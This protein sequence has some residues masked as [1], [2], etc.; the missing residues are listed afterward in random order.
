MR[1]PNQ[2]SIYIIEHT[3]NGKLFTS[4]DLEDGKINK[5]S[6]QKICSVDKEDEYSSFQD[7][8]YSILNAYGPTQSKHNPKRIYISV[9]PGYN[10]DGMTQDEEYCIENIL[11]MIREDGLD[12]TIDYYETELKLSREFRK[13][14]GY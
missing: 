5:E 13:A 14:N 3:L 9:E 4:F 10:T 12:A 6:E 8:L 11:Q 2:G 1:Y 7:F